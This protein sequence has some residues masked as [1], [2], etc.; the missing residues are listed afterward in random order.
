MPEQLALEGGCPQV[1]TLTSLTMV[2][3]CPEIPRREK[4]N[5]TFSL[6]FAWACHSKVAHIPSHHAHCLPMNPAWPP[7]PPAK[8]HAPESSAQKN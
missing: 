1:E 4:V 7:Q 5:L 6:S 3:I 2:I 8:A